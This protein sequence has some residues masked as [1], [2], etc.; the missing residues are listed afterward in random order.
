MFGGEVLLLL[1]L[2]GLAL[3]VIAASA[4]MIPVRRRRHASNTFPVVTI[5]LL[6]LNL[7]LFLGTSHG[8]FLD[9]DVARGWGL[10][11]RDSSV[12]TLLTSVFLHG[13]WLHLGGNLLGAGTGQQF[14]ELALGLGEAA[15]ERPGAKGLLVEFFARDGPAFVKVGAAI[16]LS[17]CQR[18]L[19]LKIA[20]G[21]LGGCDRL[22]AGAILQ[23][24]EGGDRLIALGHKLLALAG[25]AA[26]I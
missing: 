15:F 11:P 17:R 8:G 9:Q 12:I 10:T 2:F 24:I 5:G 18:H 25:Q 3:L 4:P 23:L 13:S 1:I 16:A 22:L 14:I 19:L 21:G 26:R 6:V 7:L 20:H